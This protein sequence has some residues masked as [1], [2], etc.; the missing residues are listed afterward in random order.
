MIRANYH[1][2]T[3]RCKHA[4][5]TVDDYCRS[6][7]DH[8]L[9]VLGMTDHAALP[10]DRW[11]GVRMPFADLDDYCREVAVARTRFP[12]LEILLAMEG[13]YAPEYHAYYQDEL[14]GRR[15]FDYLVGAVHWFPWEGAWRGTFEGSMGAPELRAY[16]EHAV[17]TLESGLFAF[18]AHPDA[19]GNAVHEWTPDAQAASRDL[20]Q[21]ACDL[22]VPLEING[23][24]RRK[25]WIDT[26]EGCRP[27]YPWERFWELAGE[28]GV[29]VVVNSDAHRPEDVV[30]GIRETTAIAERY[31]LTITAPRCQDCAC[32]VGA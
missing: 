20:I 23:Y 5:G 10:D 1:T 6:A 13:E 3:H 19:F 32:A 7:C 9:E 27:M 28:Y 29:R 4:S 22:R 12:E 14:L 21:A 15:G 24:G 2:H 18:L 31:G 17:R 30:A 8:G 26:P 25:P 16:V 11:I